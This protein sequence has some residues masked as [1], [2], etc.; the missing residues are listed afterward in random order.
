MD[1]TVV[2]LRDAEV[3]F[4]KLSPLI[5]S[6]HVITLCDGNEPVAEIRPLPRSATKRRAFGLARGTFTVPADFGSPDREI[7]RMFYVVSE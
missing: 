6:G 4:G 1:K 5:R 3:D 2:E 7:E